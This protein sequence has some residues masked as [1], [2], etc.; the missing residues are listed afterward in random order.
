VEVGESRVLVTQRRIQVGPAKALHALEDL[1]HLVRLEVECGLVA[2]CDGS[3]SHLSEADL[4]AEMLENS[5]DVRH[6][7]GQRHPAPDRPRPVAVE[8]HT[9]VRRDHVVRPTPAHRPAIAVVQSLWTIHTDRDAEAVLF[10]VVNQFLRQQHGVGRQRKIDTLAEFLAPSL[11]IR[12]RLPD[13][14]HVA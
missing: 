5:L 14:G 6:A 12:D 2:G 1:H 10:E 9:G 13:Q 8:Q 4:G 11:R 7:R 3:E